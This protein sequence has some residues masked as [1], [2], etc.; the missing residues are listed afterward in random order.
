M[1]VLLLVMATKKARGFGP[2]GNFALDRDKRL[3][4]KNIKPPRPYVML[5]AQILKPELFATVP[6]TVFSNNLIWDKAEAKSMLCG[7]EHD[8]AC[9]HVGTPE[10][11][12]KANELFGF[13]QRLAMKNVYTIPPDV[14][15]LEALVDGLVREAGDGP[16]S[17]SD[18]LILLPTRRACVWLREAFRERLKTAALLPRMQPIGDIDEDELYFSEDVNLDIPPAIAPLRRQLLLASM[19]F[20]IHGMQIDQATALLAEAFGAFVAG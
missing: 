11:L 18:S 6:D 12:A 8:G 13:R 16:F 2:E 3:H 1:D 15:F 19:I 9:Y 10:D 20:K 17:L 14:P 4:R 5:S 7:V